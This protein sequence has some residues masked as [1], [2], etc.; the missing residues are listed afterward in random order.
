MMI[1]VGVSKFDYKGLIFID[2]ETKI[3]KDYYYVVFLSQQL[4]SAACQLSDKFIHQQD[5]S[6]T[7]YLSELIFHKVVQRHV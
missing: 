7:Y 6:L 5:S 2:L 3:D 4:L 1:T